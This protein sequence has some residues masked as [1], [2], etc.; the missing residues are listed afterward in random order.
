MADGS[1]VYTAPSTIA[2][3]VPAMITHLKAARSNVPLTRQLGAHKL[4]LCLMFLQALQNNYPA[5]GIIH[6]LFTAVNKTK[7]DN[8][9]AAVRRTDL[10]SLSNQYLATATGNSDIDTPS[11]E[12]AYEYNTS[13][14]ALLPLADQI[15]DMTTMNAA[16]PYVLPNSSLKY[17][18]A[19]MPI[20]DAYQL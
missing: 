10:H 15:F 16:D 13:E 7:E 19:V 18:T 14:F 8:K 3:I 12:S 9:E 4:E 17:F 20:F 2:L 11:Q 1:A 5:A 6:R